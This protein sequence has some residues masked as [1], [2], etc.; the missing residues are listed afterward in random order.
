MNKLVIITKGEKDFLDVNDER[1]TPEQNRKL[2]DGHNSEMGITKAQEEAMKAGSMFG[3]A[4]P[5]ADP[6]NYDDKGALLQPKQKDR[7]DAR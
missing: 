3:W 4:V 5:A 6:Q 2:V 7:G 1:N